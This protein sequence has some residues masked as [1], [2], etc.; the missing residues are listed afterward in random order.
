M[1]LVDT[2]IVVDVVT[3]DADWS[4]WSASALETAAARDK[5][6]INDIDYAE[7]AAGYEEPEALHVSLDG[8]GLPL[9]RIPVAALFL[10]GQAFRQYRRAGGTR[11]S[12]LA[13]FFIGAHAAV[14]GAAL[15][16]RDTRRIRSYFP[17]VALVAPDSD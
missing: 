10:A 16:T 7:L 2:N 8:L 3:G 14:T 6:A 11:S 4:T 12:V 9:I 1:I 13:D 15:L 17:T 5:L